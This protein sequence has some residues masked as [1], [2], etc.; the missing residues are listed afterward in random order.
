VLAR[1]KKQ[2]ISSQ[3][4]HRT[5][6]G[7]VREFTLKERFEHR[8]LESFDLATQELYRLR[9]PATIHTTIYTKIVAFNQTARKHE[10]P[11]HLGFE[12]KPGK[13]IATSF[14]AK[15]A[16]TVAAGFEA[17]PIET[18]ATGL[19]VKPTK[20]V[21]ADFEVKPAKTVRVVLRSNH[22]QTVDLGFEAQPRNPRP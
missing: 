8:I 7:R 6:D 15:L 22:S 10:L 2:F 12:A 17:K 19:E 13:T 9:V 20:T 4:F 1:T 14:E 18:V 5:P 11:D 21:A 3:S 16:K